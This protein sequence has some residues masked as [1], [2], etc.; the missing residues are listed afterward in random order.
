MS[1]SYDK[2]FDYYSWINYADYEMKQFLRAIKDGKVKP[3]MQKWINPINNFQQWISHKVYIHVI[4]ISKYQAV[5]IKY[6]IPFILFKIM[7]RGTSA[8]IC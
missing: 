1:P 4:E 5:I 8:N 3:E 2:S 7:S 6:H